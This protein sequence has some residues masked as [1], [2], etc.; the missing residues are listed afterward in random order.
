VVSRAPIETASDENG[1]P[2]E[3]TH[4]PLQYIS[5][6]LKKAMKMTKYLIAK[7]KAGLGN[8]INST[9]TAILYAKLSDRVLVVDWSDYTYSQ[10]GENVFP[11][12]FNLQEIA[13]TTDI[14]DSES[15]YPAVWRGQL[16]KT[17]AE[18]VEAHD[19]GLDADNDLAYKYSVDVSR[20][21]YSEDVLVYWSY[22]HELAKLRG[23]LDRIPGLLRGMENREIL[24]TAFQ[25]HMPLS[26]E[27]KNAVDTFYSRN[28]VGQPTIGVHLRTGRRQELDDAI[29]DKYHRAIR[30]RLRAS[31]NSR[32]F[33][34]TDNIDLAEAFEKRYDNTIMTPKWYP[35]AGEDPHQN[36]KCPDRTQHGF[37]ALLDMCLLARSTY[38]I[39]MGTSSYSL[40]AWM[41]SDIPPRNVTDIAYED[42]IYA[43]IGRRINRW[44]GKN[45]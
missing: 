12:Y 9:L 34:A 4:A 26:V 2:L 45:H 23:H 25:R 30:A 43:R 10:N 3:R 41:M 18:M 6:Q 33:L 24:H 27:V 11:L 40:G 7:G 39:H 19:P 22:A 31:P 35:P 29:I 42:S 15:V 36:A 44:L 1:P 13:S 37:E 14:P 17:A 38:L 21:D 16:D 28:L 32:V 20:L 8:R 5:N